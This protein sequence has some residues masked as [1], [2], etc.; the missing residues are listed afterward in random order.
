PWE[1]AKCDRPAHKR[2]T[3]PYAQKCGITSAANIS[4][5]RFAKSSGMTPNCSMHTR[6]LNPVRSRMRAMRSRT[7][8]R[9][10][11]HHG[12]AG[13]ELLNSLVVRARAQRLAHLRG[14]LHRGK[15]HVAGRQ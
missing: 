3:V 12:A 14:T 13:G 2:G 7:R 8:L 1:V 9:T 15:R 11:D 10:A 5:F 4:M 6:M